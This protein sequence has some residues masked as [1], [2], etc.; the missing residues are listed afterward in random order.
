M[1]KVA[2][3]YYEDNTEEGDRFQRWLLFAWDLL[4]TGVELDITRRNSYQDADEEIQQNAANYDLLIADILEGDEE[5]LGLHLITTAR[6]LN[7]HIG[8]VALT[9]GK[10]KKGDLKN[11]AFKAGSDEYILKDDL[12]EREISYDELGEILL[13]ALRKHGKEPFPTET[14]KFS[15]DERDYS[16]AAIVETIGSETIMVL[17][18]KLLKESTKRIKASFIS[19]GLSGAYVL[20][21][22]CEFDVT[23]GEV[24]KKKSLFLKVSRDW[25]LLEAELGRRSEVSYYPDRMFASFVGEEIVETGREVEGRQRGWYAIGYDFQ[26]GAVT[27]IEWLV[28]RQLSND[29]IE[30]AMSTLF[31]GDNGLQGVYDASVEREIPPYSALS[32]LITPWRKAK[33]A[34]AIDDFSEIIERKLAHFGFEREILDDFLETKLIPNFDHKS[35]PK[36]S[37]HCRS[38]G[39]FHGR[40]ILVSDSGWP[41]LIDPANI[42]TLHWAADLA[43]LIV[44]LIVSG[45]DSGPDSLLLDQMNDWV[46][47]CSSVLQFDIK[48]IQVLDDSRKRIT[49]TIGWLVRNTANIHGHHFENEKKWE[50]QLAMAIEFLRASYRQELFPPKRILGLLAASTALRIIGQDN[51]K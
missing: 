38:H 15:Y 21:V 39:D 1:N 51:A 47:I 4:K 3:L 42:G 23:E 26:H 29:D 41:Y 45:L 48:P 2:C 43:R 12:T 31:L 27:L 37:Y 16:L 13:K 36:V 46:K 33:I 32:E 20:R 11:R 34:E 18:Q 5:P 6:E 40:N 8:I 25:S 49:A 22:D 35:V 30:K 24:P 28:K 7:E 19:P 44:D 10:G 17:V 50:F 9:I 14:M